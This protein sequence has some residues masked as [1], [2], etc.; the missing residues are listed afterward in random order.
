MHHVGDC[1]SRLLFKQSDDRYIKSGRDTRLEN[2]MS[3][4]ILFF[5]FRTSVSDFN[6]VLPFCA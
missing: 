4:C 1:S 2:L 3:N 5:L 6:T